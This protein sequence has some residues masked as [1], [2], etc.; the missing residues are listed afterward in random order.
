MRPCQCVSDQIDRMP[1]TALPATFAA[2]LVVLLP[3]RHDINLLGKPL[4]KWQVAKIGMTQQQLAFAVLPP[5]PIN[6]LDREL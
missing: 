3:G 4:H 5:A 2:E 1:P 6:E